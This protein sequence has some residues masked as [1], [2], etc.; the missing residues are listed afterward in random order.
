MR[1]HIRIL[2]HIEK[3]LV[4]QKNLI[5]QIVVAD[6]INFTSLYPDYLEILMSL[7]KPKTGICLTHDDLWYWSK[8]IWFQKCPQRA[9]LRWQML[10]S[11]F[12]YTSINQNGSVSCFLDVFNAEVC[13]IAESN[14]PFFC[15]LWHAWN[16][17]WKLS[18]LYVDIK[19]EW[20]MHP[21]ETTR[22]CLQ[23]DQFVKSL[24]HHQG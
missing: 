8:I 20:Q 17:N 7:K 12:F 2:G 9:Y 4:H 14:Y 10:Q 21:S 19:S 13:W 6:R 22:K 15:F 5:C 24:K 3:T 23:V 11:F 16:P 1:L 18:L